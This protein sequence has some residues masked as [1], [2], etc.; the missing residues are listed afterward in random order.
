MKFLDFFRVKKPR[1]TNEQLKFNKM[2]DLWVENKI[3]SPYSELMTYQ[4]EINNGGHDQYFFNVSN[5]RDL[6]EA[7]LALEKVLP[8][9]LKENLNTA[10]K[11]YL[12]LDENEEDEKATEILE[13]C[14]GFF[15]TY[16]S[17]INSILEDYSSKIKL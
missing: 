13:E 12:V 7:M 9:K 3:P 14:D 10:Y 6:T 11:A 16:Q 15:Y 5:T 17:E 4:S 1:L 8:P 2:W